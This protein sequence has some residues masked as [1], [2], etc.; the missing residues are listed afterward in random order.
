MNSFARAADTRH[1]IEC[2][3][4]SMKSARVRDAARKK[5]HHFFLWLGETL[6]SRT[7]SPFCRP[8]LRSSKR[9]RRPS[10][11]RSAHHH[12][13]V[14]PRP[15]LGELGPGRHYRLRPGKVVPS[16]RV[17]LIQPF[18]IGV[19]RAIHVHDG[20]S[21]KAGDVLI[22]LDPTHDDGGSGAH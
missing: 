11:A 1:S 21:V 8:R 18:E 15:D 22:E 7:N 6:V 13:A 16:G 10:A 19:V 17:K 9:R 5:C 14:L 3:V 12:G 4:V 20:Q 2:K